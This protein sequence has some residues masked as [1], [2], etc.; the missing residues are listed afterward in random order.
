MVYMVY[1]VYGV[2]KVKARKVKVAFNDEVEELLWEP[3]SVLR[4]DKL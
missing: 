4:L 2:G 3:F 1:Y